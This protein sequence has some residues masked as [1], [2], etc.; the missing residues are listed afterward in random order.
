MELQAKKP[1]GS[2]NS[3]LGMESGAIADSA[4]NASSSYVTTVGPRYA[5][6]RKEA[7]GGA[8]CPK[9]QIESGIREWIL[10]DLGTTHLITAI[11]TQGRYDHGRGQEYT[12]NYAVEYWRPG[13]SEWKQ[14]KLWDGT[15][16][17]A[18]NVDTST[19]PNNSGHKY[20]LQ[21]TSC[22]SVAGG[23]VSYTIPESPVAELNDTSYDGVREYG[24]LSAGLGRLIDG[25]TGADNY[26]Q[27][28]ADGRGTGWVAWMRDSFPDKYVELTF[29]F[30]GIRIFDAVHIY[31]NNYFTRDV[32]V[33]AKADV[34]FSSS[35]EIDEAAEPLSYTYIPDT[36]LEN[37][38]NVSIALH[39]RQ[40]KVLRFRLYFAARWIIISEVTFDSWN[41][42]AN[43]TEETASEISNEDGSGVEA[44]S[45][46]VA[47]GPVNH[48]ADLNLQTITAREEGQE[49]VEVLIGVLTAITLL[50]LLVFIIILLLSR[51][52]KLQ[53]SPTVLKNPFGFA[54]NMKGFLLNLAPG[55]MLN[56]SGRDSPD[57]ADEEEP[58]GPDD[59]EEEDVDVELDGLDD[60]AANLVPPDD[61]SMRESLTMEHFNSPLVESQYKSTYAIV[62]NT[63]SPSRELQQRREELRSSKSFEK[64][65]N[66]G[67]SRQQDSCSLTLA[68]SSRSC[69][70]VSSAH[71]SPSTRHSQHYRTLQ[72]HAARL[73]SAS[74]EHQQQQQQQ[75]QQQREP[76]YTHVKRW[77]TAPKEKHKVPAPLVKW[78]IAPSMGKPYKCKEIE[79]ANI[80]GQCLHTMEKLGSGHIGE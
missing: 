19:V 12:E 26:K 20:K 31:T 32:Q 42:Y 7:A 33:F 44:G 49:Y 66:S 55:R 13:F 75:Q 45:V 69:S 14:Y 48:D 53:S 61:L 43:A 40:G 59:E 54:I 9:R 70:P 16:V 23:V 73:G 3:A 57:L 39:G 36:N 74:R 64:G 17:L 79:P 2:C 47:T 28:I 4:L 15:E 65:Y 24:V 78:N 30:D 10:I 52:Q 22:V 37:A 21:R 5:R 50:L 25:E 51:R 46:L 1:H 60:G 62:A 63:D 29:H 34:W 72:G 76:D 27:D 68:G 77:N 18:G 41:P 56:D 80:P 38:R 71:Y 6:L 8:W 11:E 67:S 58:D 35:G